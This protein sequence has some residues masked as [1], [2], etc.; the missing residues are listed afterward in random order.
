MKIGQL[1]IDLHITN[2]L[3]YYQKLFERVVVSMT[4]IINKGLIIGLIVILLCSP[5]INGLII[6]PGFAG[7]AGERID[8]ETA[9]DAR[10]VREDEAANNRNHNTRGIIGPKQLLN[11]SDFSQVSDWVMVNA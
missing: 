1:K 6:F 5:L 3:Y 8:A 10:S 4:K 11:N 2:P 7:E 9:V